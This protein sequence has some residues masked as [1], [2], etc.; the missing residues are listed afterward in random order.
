MARALLLDRAANGE[1][2]R[3]VEEI[4]MVVLLVLFTILTFLT[5]DYFVQR[6]ARRRTVD[7][8]VLERRPTPALA[9]G[10]LRPPADVFL[11]PG[12][13]WLRLEP[14]GTVRVGADRLAPALLGGIA[15]SDIR[16]RGTRVHRGEP[17]ATLER[18]GRSVTLRSPVDGI[19][20]EVNSEAVR[21]P[22]VLGEDPYGDGWIARL[23]PIGLEKALG[24]LRVARE[25]A[26]WMRDE[27]RRLRD[28]LFEGS[29]Q[30]AA[31][32]PD[33]GFPVDGVAHRLDAMTWSRVADD[34]FG[35]RDEESRS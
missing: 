1:C 22:G 25:A 30:L 16:P 2:L 20:S 6:S 17:I 24:G 13:A 21:S 29:P 31:T 18:D 5:V 34:V 15:R 23:E 11:S 4:T 12:H 9:Y 14:A 32:L 7:E 33:G 19:V 35:D 8:G 28:L 27:L 26:A 3:A 10:T